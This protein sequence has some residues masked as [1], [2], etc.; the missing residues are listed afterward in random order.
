MRILIVDDHTLLRAGLRRILE[1]E[2]SDCVVG[3]A[4]S[5]RELL[6]A[7]TRHDWNIVL[8]DI[9]LP[10]R[11]GLDALEDLRRARPDLPVLVLSMHGEEPFALR[12]FRAGASGYVTK[13]RAPD[14]LLRAVQRVVSG[15]R[16]VSAS[17]AEKL[18]GVVARD[19]DDLPHERLSQRE[20]EVFRAL[21]AGKTVTEVASALFLSVKTVSTYRTR[22]FEKT[23]L[24]TNADLT[25][26]ALQHGLIQ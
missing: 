21:A 8:L 5:A 12:A 10:D 11:S 16:Y 1:D 4:A 17:L 3:E 15:G 6:E 13:E 20:F 14:E 26:Y 22:I 23:E 18:V 7:V 24:A 25:R 9:G 2:L 19:R